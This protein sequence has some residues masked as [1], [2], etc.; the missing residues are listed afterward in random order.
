MI[1]LSSLTDLLHHAHILIISGSGRPTKSNQWHRQPISLI[2]LFVELVAKVLSLRLA[3]RF[4]TLVSSNQSTFIARRCIHDNFLVQQMLRRRGLPRRH[5]PAKLP[6]L[7]PPAN[8]DAVLAFLA[9]LGLSSADAA[10]L[11]VRDPKLLCA[12]V[13]KTLAPVVVGL[14]GLGLS[15]SEITRLALLAADAFRKKAIVSK[16]HYYMGVFGSTDTFFR[17]MKCCNVLSYSLERV[18][19]PNVAYLRE[20]GLR[21]C[22]IAKLCLRRPRIIITNPERVQEMVGCAESIGVPRYSGMFRHALNA[23]ASFSKE[24]IAA[25]VEHLKNTFT[26]TD[27]EVSIA[28]SKAPLLLNRSKESLQRRS[29]FLISEVGLE[30]SYIAHRPVM[31]GL[32][33]EGRLMP[34]YYAVKFL[35]ENGLLRHGPSYD[36]IIKLTEKAFRKQFIYMPS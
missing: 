5:L 9:G 7:K 30:P 28:V 6:H 17:V 13:E 31:L 34:R 27:A 23:V 8:P 12:R 4:S 11:V 25:R 35:K 3:L 19:K 10:A 14:T 21:D 29:E 33:L 2:H 26:W 20:C 15:R 16:L 36:T 24:E 18:V 22:D 32:S 1:A